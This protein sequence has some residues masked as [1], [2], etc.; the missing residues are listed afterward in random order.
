MT[1]RLT[2]NR[3]G[4][5]RLEGVPYN[6]A[7]V[8]YICLKCNTLNNEL[9]GKDLLK[10]DIAYETSKWK[11][12]KCGFIHSRESNLP[13]KSGNWPN[14]AKKATS[15]KAQRFWEAFF[16]ISTEHSESYWKQCNTCGRIL[17]FLSFSKHSGFGPLERQMECR[18]CKG[19]IN[20]VLNPKRTKQQL[21]EA[22][23]RRRVAELFVE[24]SNEKVDI[25]KLFDRFNHRCFKTNKPLDINEKGTWEIDHILP[26]KW[27]YPLSTANAALLSR[28]ANQNK[29]D[30]WPSQFYTNTELIE[31]AKITGADL[32]L[33]TSRKPIINK[34]ID[35]NNGVNKYLSVREK[36]DLVKRIKEIKKIL[37]DYDL[38]S[39]LSPANKRLLGF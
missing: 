34:H 24:D 23:I 22:S 30:C 15:V 17:P 4:I 9:V 8:G 29:R 2:K 38:I 5:G 32:G 18:C 25:K 3:T 27:L 39:G 36:S 14:A 7:W 26:S 13:F 12:K 33:L 16:R 1:R 11:C 6:D 37:T 31:L 28:N 10:P 21:Y 20:A 19:A 35:I